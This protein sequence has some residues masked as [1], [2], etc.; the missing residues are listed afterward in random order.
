MGLV[1]LDLA[2]AHRLGTQNA[3]SGSQVYSLRQ[4]N[5]FH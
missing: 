5:S 3:L 4:S 2:I 1:E